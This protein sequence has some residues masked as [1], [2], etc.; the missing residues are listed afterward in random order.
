MLISRRTLAW[1]AAAVVA[2]GLVAAWQLW[3]AAPDEPRAGVAPQARAVSEGAM[4][5]ASAAADASPGLREPIDLMGLTVDVARLF[6]IGYAG[7]LTIDERTLDAL[8]TVLS[9]MPEHWDA[10]D[11]ERLSWTL[12]DGLPA[13][14]AQRALGLI[15]TYRDYLGQARAQ[16]QQWGIPANAQDAQ[17]FFDRMQALQRQHFGA[18]TAQAL[19]GEG[20]EHGRVVM[21]AA[22][23]AQD[24]SL[25]PEERSARLQA[26]RERLPPQ[27][28]QA[29][30]E[31][32]SVAVSGGS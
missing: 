2:V 17:Q 7:G 18:E 9:H 6:D 30:V 19:F 5:Q 15:Q 24:A 14:D 3:Q 11:L 10:Q 12:R 23:V 31:E 1:L 22:F 32:P 26:L 13:A 28:Q 29:I 4:P 20:M 21:E 25:S 16:L 27:L 8:E